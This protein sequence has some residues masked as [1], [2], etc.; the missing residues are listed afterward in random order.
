MVDLAP[1]KKQ[2]LFHVV[3]HS[4]YV[5][6]QGTPEDDIVEL[7]YLEGRVDLYVQVVVER[8][9]GC[10]DNIVVGD[11]GTRSRPLLGGRFGYFV[12][13]CDARETQR[14]EKNGAHLA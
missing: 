7:Q 6:D 9:I 4:E 8:H 12:S 5:G 13:H 2:N 1:L 14:S 3:E 10:M 11:V